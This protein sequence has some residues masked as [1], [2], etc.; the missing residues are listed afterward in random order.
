M[1]GSPFAVRG[2]IEGFYGRPWSQADRLDLLAFMGRHDLNTYVYAPKDDPL[3][4]RDWRVAYAGA[5][6]AALRELVDA[7]GQHGVDVVWSISPGLSIEYSSAADRAALT[8]KLRTVAALGIRWFALLLDDI[9][10]TLQHESDKAAFEDLT[11]AQISLVNEVW[12]Q[13]AA[14]ERLI[15]CPTLYH[16][17]GDEP[18]ITRLGQGIDPRIDLFWTGR[19]IC[20]P[21]IDLADAAVFARATGR[22]AT[23]WDNYPV[24]DLAM[25]IELH[26]GPYRG[27]DRHLYR[28]AHGI[29]ANAMERYESSKIAL[30]TMAEYLADPEA[31]DPEAAWPRAIAEVTGDD[32]DA[33]A[34]ATFADNVRKSA[35]SYDD[36]PGLARALEAFAF[37]REYGA[38]GA[39]AAAGLAAFADRLLAATDHLLRGPVV[40]GRLVDE[41]RP[42]LER[43]ELGGRALRCMADLEAA[44]RLAADGPRELGGYLDRLRPA[45]VRVFGDTLEMALTDVTTS[46]TTATTATTHPQGQQPGGGTP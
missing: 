26:V 6:L 13:L 21:T 45:E 20:S 5:E 46:A 42:W 25:A 43:V 27:R 3:V 16:G 36:A 32:R 10:D 4:R 19:R 30:A 22:P 40:N 18:A 44:G 23:F 17:A 8:A 7:G 12:G 31:Y 29:V 14:G 1:S 11:A 24:N 35:L 37:E 33:E 2:V 34:Y 15:V 38:G 28:F 39:A 9:P 41:A